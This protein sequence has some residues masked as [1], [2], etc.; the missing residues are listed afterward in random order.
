[1]GDTLTMIGLI[2]LGLSILVTIHELGH[3]M[4]ARW[5]GMRVEIFS[6]FFPPKI[7]GIKRGETEYQIGAIP[8]GG[9]VKISGM[10]D[11]SMDK[12]H[13]KKE[14]ESYEFRSK[15]A[16]QR[17][18]V[19]CGGVIMNVILGILIFFIVKWV[20]GDVM[21]P[22]SAVKN[23]I[24]VEEGSVAAEL[25]FKSGDKLIMFNGD[26]IKYLDE[27][28]NPSI[29]LADGSYFDVDRGGKMVRIDIPD[30]FLD[31]FTERPDSEKVIFQYHF[32]SRILVDSSDKEI[33]SNAFDAGLR[34][35]DLVTKFDST[36]IIDWNS[37][38][39]YLQGKKNTEVSVTV[40]RDGKELVFSVK[41]DTA[42]HIGVRPDFERFYEIKKYN[43]FQALGKGTQQ[44]FVSVYTTIQ[45]LGKVITGKADF[46]KSISG[47]VKIAQIYGKGFDKK[48]WKF[49]WELTGMLSM[50][51]AFM[52]ILPIPALDGGHVIF[53]LI[54][55]ISGREPNPKVK[56]I[57][58][59]IGMVLLLLLIGFIILNDILN[60]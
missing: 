45:G 30:D 43:F 34:T 38:T 47:P 14:P 59:Q 44:A 54:E 22:M 52:N 15:P 27:V 25:N 3:F 40:D 41:T 24:F 17:L 13:L 10:I 28:N 29:L 16:W 35:G 42:G 36:E 39:D 1:M 55:M 56:I 19:M 8:L 20:S 23:G 7:F 60:W 33:P 26:T 2:I 51:L 58:Q 50:I 9:F 12:E 32:E 46:S 57:A 53:I 11:E 31:K 37:M 6:L 49:F 5:F 48:G 18:I 21:L 4:T